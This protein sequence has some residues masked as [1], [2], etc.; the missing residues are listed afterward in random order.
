MN[1]FL[2]KLAFFLLP[3]KHHFSYPA[4]Y[5][6]KLYTFHSLISYFYK[7]NHPYLISVFMIKEIK[8]LFKGF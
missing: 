1:N 8:F 5:F 3:A 6:L 7:I 4:Y 2:T